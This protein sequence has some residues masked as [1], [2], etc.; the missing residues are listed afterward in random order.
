[1]NCGGHHVASY[2]LEVRPALQ[3]VDPTAPTDVVLHG[4][5]FAVPGRCIWKHASQRTWGTRC[6]LAQS[7][8]NSLANLCRL[9]VAASRMLNT[10]KHSQNGVPQLDLA[11]VTPCNLQRHTSSRQDKPL[12]KECQQHPPGPP[13]TSC[14][15]CPAAART[16]RH[17]TFKNTLLGGR[18]SRYLRHAQ[19]PPGPPATSC[20]AC[21]AAAQT[22]RHATFKI[23]CWEAG[24]AAT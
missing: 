16:A 22:A 14:T 3:T 1:M 8:P 6:S 17:A 15:A 9:A 24:Q 19:H 2:S 4:T 20:T 5:F 13:A 10:C 21:P 7:G 23:H 18:A 11:Q 12:H